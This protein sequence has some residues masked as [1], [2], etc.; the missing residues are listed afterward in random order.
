MSKLTLCPIKISVPINSK[1]FGRTFSI[2]E[3]FFYISLVIYVKQVIY[4]S[5]PLFGLTKI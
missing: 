5:I 2:I 4:S 3:A 1:K